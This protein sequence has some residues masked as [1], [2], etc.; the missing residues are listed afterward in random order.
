MGRQ[1]GPNR[2]IAIFILFAAVVVDA[3]AIFVLAPVGHKDHMNLV[4]DCREV[5]TDII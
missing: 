5:L 1:H 4:V 2:S 3:E